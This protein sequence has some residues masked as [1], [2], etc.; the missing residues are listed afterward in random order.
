V[1]EKPLGGH[2]RN[3]GTTG[4]EI[5]ISTPGASVSQYQRLATVHQ[6]EE[7]SH[8]SEKEALDDELEDELE[9]EGQ[10]TIRPK[11]S[12]PK[13]HLTPGVIL[14][15]P[16]H[17][18]EGN[19]GFLFFAPNCPGMEFQFKVADYY[20]LQVVIFVD[21]QTSLQAIQTRHGI[22]PPKSAIMPQK[23]L[24]EIA[25]PWPVWPYSI[26]PSSIIKYPEYICLKLEIV[27]KPRTNDG[28]VKA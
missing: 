4:P 2:P 1:F 8:S 26:S 5:V 12:G 28:F 7:T 20:V 10:L 22:D 21:L 27:T 16:Q 25:L 6:R 24:S 14:P 15:Y 13:F 3:L 11:T 9:D 18:R 17:H 19:V 23:Y